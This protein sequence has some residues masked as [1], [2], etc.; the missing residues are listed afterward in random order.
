MSS[1]MGGFDALYFGRID[2]QDRALRQNTSNLEMIWRASASTG[3]NTQTFAGAMPGYGPPDGR[4]CWDEVAC[5]GTDPI[6]DDILL[7]G[8]NVDSIVGIAVEVANTWY[9]WHVIHDG[10][11]SEPWSCT[12]W[13]LRLRS[14]EHSWP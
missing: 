1:P 8:Y 12:L 6:V 10:S 11:Q 5:S 2:Y 4:L 9:P 7:E 14:S 13:T 3:A